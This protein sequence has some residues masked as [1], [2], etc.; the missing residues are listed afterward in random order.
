MRYGYFKISNGRGMRS[1]GQIQPVFERKLYF[2]IVPHPAK[3]NQNWSRNFWDYRYKELH[4]DRQT[5]RQTKN[6]SCPKTKFLGQVITKH[7]RLNKKKGGGQVCV[8]LNTPN[9]SKDLVCNTLYTVSN[10]L[11]VQD[12][13]LDFP[14]WCMPA[15]WAP[16]CLF[17]WFLSILIATSFPR[18]IR[19][20]RR[21]VR[22]TT[23][24]F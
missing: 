17:V 13:W 15:D 22:S 1:T 14:L 11:L 10:F 5:D 12:R 9:F 16:A 18:I 3:F 19:F 2:I 7:Q 4:T 21:F 8:I 24:I 23:E 6:N 20:L